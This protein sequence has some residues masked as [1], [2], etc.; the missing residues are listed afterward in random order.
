M[1][2]HSRTRVRWGELG[3]LTAAHLARVGEKIRSSG[4]TAVATGRR[5]TREWGWVRLQKGL[6]GRG[7]GSNAPHGVDQNGAR[8]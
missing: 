2:P 4:A 6:T 8:W 7:S 3:R 1:E 5:E